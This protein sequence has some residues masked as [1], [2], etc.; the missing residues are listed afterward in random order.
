MD[1]QQ[2]VGYLTCYS[3]WEVR[4]LELYYCTFV[5][6]KIAIVWSREYCDDCGEFLCSRPFVHFESFSLSLMCSDNR[7]NFVLFELSFSQ[8]TSKEIR[9]SSYIIMLNYIFTISIFVVN[10]VSPHQVAEKASFW[11]FPKPIYFFDVLKLG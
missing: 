3:K 4:Y 2:I 5:I 9:T 1:S 11:N 8:F 7:Y 10:W 6:V